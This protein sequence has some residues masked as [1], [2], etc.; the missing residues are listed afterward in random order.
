MAPKSPLLQNILYRLP[1]IIISIVV[2]LLVLPT[3]T[4]NINDPN[5]IPYFNNDEGGLMDL[6][7][8]YYSGEKRPTFQWDFD[9]GLEMRYIADFARL[10]LSRFVSFTPGL[11]VLILRCFHLG[12][13][14][15]SFFALYRLVKYHFGGKWQPIFAVLL[16]AVSPSMN[17][18]FSNIK[19]NPLIVL[20]MIVGL[21][22]TL[23]L[24]EDPFQKRNILIAIACASLAFLVQFAG[25]LLLPAIVA[26]LFLAR[27]YHGKRGDAR[28]IIPELKI[29]WIL[30]ALGG[31]VM[32]LFPVIIIF[33]YVRKSTGFTWYED[34]GFWGTL[35]EIR[36]ILFLW[37]VGGIAIL[38]SLLILVLNKNQNP[39]VKKIMFWVNLIN[40]SIL[41]VCGIFAG[42]TVIFGFRWLVDPKHFINIFGQFAPITVLSSKAYVEKGILSQVAYVWY[43]VMW[44]SPFIFALF[45]IYLLI[46]FYPPRHKGRKLYLPAIIMMILL[47]IADIT[48]RGKNTVTER[49]Y[50]FRQHE[51][52]VF[53]LAKW[54]RESIPED[55]R[56]VSDFYTRAY[57]PAGYKNVKT[58]HWNG[59]DQ[60]GELRQLVETYKPEFIYYNR[61]ANAIDSKNPLPPISEI[62]PN[63]RVRKVA[64]F[65]AENENAYK[66]WGRPSHFLIYKVID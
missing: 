55:S 47:C 4:N 44:L 18:F 45:L 60:V 8:F 22:Y 64:E 62:L 1:L 31:I 38:L 66:V 52:V 53:E 24:I 40:S 7:W 34:F 48:W 28:S 37:G 50:Q 54:W 46:E 30:P 26:A 13:W 12:A 65:K 16:L 21:D 15:L 56:I 19:P 9:Y 27:G 42:L 11:F 41:I 58:A 57:I 3:I 63:T 10:V 14:I 32:I 39:F 51:A 6:I 2:L 5:M 36:A 49:L 17:Y 23:R 20:I 33:S 43:R 61:S 59:K 35:L 25:L 29:S